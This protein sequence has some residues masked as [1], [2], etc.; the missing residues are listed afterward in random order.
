MGLFKYFFLLSNLPCALINLINCFIFLILLFIVSLLIL[1]K[2][3][4]LEFI[5]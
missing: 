3:L 4:I 1:F 5:F 2:P